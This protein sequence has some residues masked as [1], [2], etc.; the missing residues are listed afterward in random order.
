V[1]SLN[2]PLD[3][4]LAGG[5]EEG[6]AVERETRGG[7]SNAGFSPSVPVRLVASPSWEGTGPGGLGEGAEAGE[8]GEVEVAEDQTFSAEGQERARQ[9]LELEEAGEVGEEE[10][11]EGGGDGLEAAAGGP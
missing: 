1:D 7:T 3:R 6:E 5:R 8:E 11:K 4:S 2:T 10:V 9:K